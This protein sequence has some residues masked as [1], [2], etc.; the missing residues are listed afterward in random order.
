[1]CAQESKVEDSDNKLEI[2]KTIIV[3]TTNNLK[4]SAIESVFEDLGY[5][6]KGLNNY[7]S[8]VSEYPNGREET[9]MGALYRAQH[10]QTE[11]PN[12]HLWIGIESGFIDKNGNKFEN[13]AKWDPLFV[14]VA[15]VILQNESNA[16]KNKLLFK[17]NKTVF[18]SKILLCPITAQQRYDQIADA[19]SIDSNQN[20]INKTK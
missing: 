20:K 11:Y 15:I 10:C 1:M 17:S 16:N 2:E 7:E 19:I 14:I 5:K 13:N 3:G 18:W 12:S 9:E 8:K 4:I 6:V